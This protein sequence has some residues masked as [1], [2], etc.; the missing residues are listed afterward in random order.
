MC[1][2]S[3][4]LSYTVARMLIYVKVPDGKT[5]TLTVRASDT[6]K[7]VKAKIEDKEGIPPD[8]QRL[9]FAGKELEDGRTVF[10]YPSIKNG[11]TLEL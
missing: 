1:T 8:D 7:T 10:D 4:L 6:I 3:I 11:S 9:K 2:S 5:I